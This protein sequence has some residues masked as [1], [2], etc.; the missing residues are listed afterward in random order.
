MKKT[1]TITINGAPIAGGTIESWVLRCWACA[2]KWVD[3]N[4]GYAQL[5]SG[6]TMVIEEYRKGVHNG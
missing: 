2:K 4:G 6:K 1:W 3:K 5:I